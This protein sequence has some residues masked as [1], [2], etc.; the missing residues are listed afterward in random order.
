MSRSNVHRRYSPHTTFSL[1]IAGLLLL[2]LLAALRSTLISPVFAASQELSLQFQGLGPN[3]GGVP[4]F[5][6]RFRWNSFELSAHSFTDSGPALTGAYRSIWRENSV[7][8]PSLNLSLRRSENDIQAGPGLSVALT[9]PFFGLGRLGLRLD[10]DVLYSI[11]SG[12]FEPE[13]LLGITFVRAGG[14]R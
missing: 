3:A 11:Q 5:G 9:F 2:S 4:V 14:R 7:V 12:S 10:N 6:G 1:G 8:S 13:Y